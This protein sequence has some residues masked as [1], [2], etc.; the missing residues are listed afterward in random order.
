MGTRFEFVS[1][2]DMD[3]QLDIILQRLAVDQWQHADDEQEDGVWGHMLERMGF[4]FE[5]FAGASTSRGMAMR[6]WA[7][8]Y[9][10]RPDLIDNETI[11]VAADRFEVS[12]QRL[13]E[14]LGEM[15]KRT[16]ITYRSKVGMAEPERARKAIDAMSAARSAKAARLRAR[17]VAV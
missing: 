11:Q 14:V 6:V 8:L 1:E 3:G 4:L 12:Q 15:K 9:A 7:V 5:F 10:V 13:C 17:E 2:S 16:G